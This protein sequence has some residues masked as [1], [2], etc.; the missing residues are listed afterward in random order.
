MSKKQGQTLSG[1]WLPLLSAIASDDWEPQGWMCRN[2]VHPTASRNEMIYSMKKLSPVCIAYGQGTI[3][4]QKGRNVKGLDHVFMPRFGILRTQFSN[5]SS[6][7]RHLWNL[8]IDALDTYKQDVVEALRSEDKSSP[9][10]QLFYSAVFDAVQ[11]QS[12]TPRCEVVVLD[13]F[14]EQVDRKYVKSESEAL[15]VRDALRVA[16][17]GQPVSVV[18]SCWDQRPVNMWSTTV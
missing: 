17:Q 9:E 2:M 8:F 15:S 4:Q 12:R 16:Y 18:V 7:D 13:V 1:R 6:G 10:F 3:W 11:R 5:D 14:G